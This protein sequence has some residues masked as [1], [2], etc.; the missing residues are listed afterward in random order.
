MQDH[1]T[2]LWDWFMDHVALLV[3]ALAVVAILSVAV[4]SGLV[5]FG[6]S[7]D[8]ALA[9]EVAVTIAVVVGAIVGM[10]WLVLCIRD[11]CKKD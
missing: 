5:M 11:A 6:T 9:S 3:L 7:S 2:P 10:V 1:G 4:G 8:W